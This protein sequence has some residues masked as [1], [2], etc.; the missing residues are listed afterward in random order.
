MIAPCER[1]T[2]LQKTLSRNDLRAKRLNANDNVVPPSTKETN[3]RGR[4]GYADDDHD[5]A[6]LA[7]DGMIWTEA[8][9]RDFAHAVLRH[10]IAHVR[11]AAKDLNLGDKMAS[12][13]VKG[14]T[15]DDFEGV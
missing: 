13:L 8:A 11:K 7:N 9:Q 5:H 10:A 3:R 12:L 6:D 15:L 4:V 2:S 14:L 1:S